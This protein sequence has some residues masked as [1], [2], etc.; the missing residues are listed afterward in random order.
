MPIARIWL[1][2]CHIGIDVPPEHHRTLGREFLVTAGE[3][4]CLH[5]VFENADAGL[6]VLEPGAGDLVEEHYLLEPNDSQLTR[7]F[8]VKE[9]RGGGFATRDNERAA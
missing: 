9:R 8:V 4:A 1:A 2:P 5:I 7:G 3:F 6:G